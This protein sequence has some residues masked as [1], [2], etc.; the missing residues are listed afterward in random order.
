MKSYFFGKVESLGLDIY[1]IIR[2]VEGTIDWTGD[3]I[4][5]KVI[6]LMTQDYN[7]IANFLRVEVVGV[8]GIL[9]GDY[10]PVPLIRLLQQD[11]T[12]VVD[13]ICQRSGDDN[14]RVHNYICTLIRDE[15]V[16]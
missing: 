15:K 16:D 6:E 13:I 12:R 5:G 14:V 10:Q 8:L 9:L 3:H 11:I 2:L 7:T 4:D 1:S